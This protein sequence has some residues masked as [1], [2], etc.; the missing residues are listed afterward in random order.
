MS[1]ELL[2]LVSTQTT[3]TYCTVCF[4]ASL[5]EL[6]AVAAKRNIR[7]LPPSYYALLKDEEKSGEDSTREP[8]DPSGDSEPS[9][10]QVSSL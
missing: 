10:A 1:I 5:I 2:C 7:R 4:A 3:V 6:K 8:S 9:R